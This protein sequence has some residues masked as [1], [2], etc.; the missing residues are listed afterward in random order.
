MEISLFQPD[1][2]SSPHVDSVSGF[3][4][5]RQK[6]QSH[7]Q[8]PCGANHQAATQICSYLFE[9]CDMNANC[10]VGILDNL[11]RNSERIPRS[12][13]EHSGLVRPNCGGDPAL[14][15]LQGASKVLPDMM[16]GKRGEL[17]IPGREV[18]GKD[19]ELSC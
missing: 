7:N 4:L 2:G 18:I 9:N 15:G 19:A 3:V 5:R 13:S 6:N 10:R 12:L 16:L 17:F 8:E 1:S 11:N 14:A